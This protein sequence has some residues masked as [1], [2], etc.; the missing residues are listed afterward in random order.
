MT[1]GEGVGAGEEEEVKNPVGWLRAGS[2]EPEEVERTPERV[3][4]EPTGGLEE[5]TLLGGAGD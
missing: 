4:G 1:V 2:R 5:F 3:A